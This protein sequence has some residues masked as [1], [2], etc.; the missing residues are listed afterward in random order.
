MVFPPTR[1]CPAIRLSYGQF[2]EEYAVKDQKY[3]ANA[4][5][6]KVVSS[7]AYQCY[8]DKINADGAVGSEPMYNDK[9]ICKIY[10][11]I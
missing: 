9:T 5:Y 7:G 11:D 10:N 2:L 6:K 1:D 8:C 3:V 4:D